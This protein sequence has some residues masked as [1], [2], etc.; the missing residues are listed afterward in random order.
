MPEIYLNSLKRKINYPLWNNDLEHN[1]LELIRSTLYDAYFESNL[2]NY[3]EED[4][5]MFA[6]WW[7]NH[8]FS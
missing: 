6:E 4:A 7:K 8:L 1:D 2:K 5:F 3:C